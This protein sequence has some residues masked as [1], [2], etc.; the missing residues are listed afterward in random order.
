MYVLSKGGAFAGA[1]T[2]IS[3]GGMSGWPEV[4]EPESSIITALR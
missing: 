3:I 4:A 2:D 1:A